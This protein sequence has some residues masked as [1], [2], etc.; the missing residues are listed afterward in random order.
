MPVA[1]Y[2]A[3]LTDGVISSTMTSMSANGTV[4]QSPYSP[5]GIPN[6]IFLTTAP[7]GSPCLQSSLVAGDASTSGGRRSE[8]GWP[9]D[10]ALAERWYTVE[11]YLPSSF[12]SS[13][14]VCLFQIHDQWNDSADSLWGSG[15]EKWVNLGC[16]AKNGKFLFLIPIDAPTDTWINYRIGGIADLLYDQWAQL[17]VH[18][19]WATDT[20]GFYEI[21]YG[22]RKVVSE[23]NKAAGYAEPIGPA[24]RFGVY[25]SSNDPHMGVTRTAWYRNAAIYAGS[26]IANW[27]DIFVSSAQPK[28][29]EQFKLTATGF[30]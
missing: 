3:S 30:R 28:P 10:G 1:L 16:H 12:D 20:T 2:S 24:V 25:A 4:L 27:Q 19:N 17:V 14:Q 18:A 22:G 15:H 8:I 21:W 9:F 5:S 7:D 11:I 26:A 23:W 29:R 6:H 13:A